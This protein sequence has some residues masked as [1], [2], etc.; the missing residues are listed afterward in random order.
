[1]LQMECDAAKTAAA[2]VALSRS[3]ANYIQTQ[4]MSSQT[5]RDKV[6]VCKPWL[7]HLLGAK[8]CMCLGDQLRKNALRI[9]SSCQ[10]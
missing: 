1:M 9:F 7:Y 2:V 8:V 6:T 5:Q 10:Q 3:D 4:L